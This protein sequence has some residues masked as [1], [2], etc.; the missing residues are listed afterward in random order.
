MKSYSDDQIKRI[1]AAHEA[2]VE[3]LKG[4]MSDI[5]IA[6]FYMDYRA[7]ENPLIAEN[8]PN[9]KLNKT[10]ED[11]WKYVEQKAS[12]MPRKGNCVKIVSNQIFDWLEEYFID[13]NIKKIETAKPTPVA[14]SSTSTPKLSASLLE[15]TRKQYEDWQTTQKEKIDKWEKEHL[16]KIDKW[17]E[18]HQ[19][20]L[21]F[22]A[23]QHPFVNEKN[24]HLEEINP[25]AEKLKQLEAEQ[26]ENTKEDK[27]EIKPLSSN[28]EPIQ[29]ENDP[30]EDCE[31]NQDNEDD[32][33]EF[34]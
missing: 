19:N 8:Y 22:D 14:K 1:V 6:T 17:C 11:A 31:D 2:E 27:Q 3:F 7:K 16:A 23:T 20:E 28:A 33:P 9:N 29:V 30:L 12:K 25:F 21:F 13:E 10:I 4:N 15:T 26:K 18:Q 24:P 34:F 32:I 5:E